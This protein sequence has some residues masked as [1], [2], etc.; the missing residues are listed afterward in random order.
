MTIKLNPKRVAIVI[1]RKGR[2]LCIY[3]EL[4]RSLGSFVHSGPF[5][6]LYQIQRN[7]N[8]HVNFCLEVLRIFLVTFFWTGYSEALKWCRRDVSI[9]ISKNVIRKYLGGKI[10]LKSQF[11]A[12]FYKYKHYSLLFSFNMIYYGNF[13]HNKPKQYLNLQNTAK[14]YDSSSILSPRH[15]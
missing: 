14:N 11:S 9:F 4:Y 8:P 12:A 10:Q 6:E 7:F 3:P 15:D 13:N 5:I 2:S 1:R